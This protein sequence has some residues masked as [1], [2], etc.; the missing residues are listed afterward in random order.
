MAEQLDSDKKYSKDFPA[1][2][3]LFRD[4][5]QG[6][7]MYVIQS[8]KVRIAVFA[9]EVEKTLAVLGPGEF[10]GE[11]AIL[12][13]RPRSATAV[14]EEDASLLVIEPR[15]FESMLRKNSEVAIRLIRKLADRLERTDRA[16]EILLHREPRARVILGLSSLARDRGERTDEGIIVRISP[17]ELAEHV[18]LDRSLAAEAL[19]RLESAGML[20]VD[21]E[22]GT[23][24]VRDVERVQEFLGYLEMKERFGDI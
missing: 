3:I 4:G 2:S 17:S 7:E 11:L 13:N 10:F 1:G 22:Q 24:L 12:N 18:G 5:D 21:A 8:G 23:L 15:A 6:D 14:I 16:V 20:S 9:G 19:K